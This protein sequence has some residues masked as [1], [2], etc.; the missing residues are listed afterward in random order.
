MENTA[1]ICLKCDSNRLYKDGV[2]YTNEGQI[3]RYLCRV[4]GYRFSESS[5]E[6]HV[7]G[8]VSESLHSGQDDH[9]VRVASRDAS[10]E[11][12]DDDLSFFYGEDVSSHD[13]SIAEK[14]LYDLPFHNSKR[15]L[16]VLEKA[17]K[18]DTATK[19]KNVAGEENQKLTVKGQLLQFALHCRNEGL[20]EETVRIWYNHLK[21]LNKK[22]NL[23]EPESVKEYLSNTTYAQGTKYNIAVIYNA[24]LN[25]IGKTWKRPKYSI[26]E[27]LP[28]F[29]PTEQEIDTLISGCGKKTATILRTI[30]ETGMRI[31]EALRLKWAWLDTERN[32]LTRNNPEKHGRPRAFKVSSKLIGMLTAL[33]KKNELIFA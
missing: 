9:E 8:K 5:V 22:A 16:C 6:V 25:L 33:P 23:D 24:Y 26:E 12:V 11:K 4:C 10:D 30:K 3:Q 27:K 15:Q 18:L 29:I 28:E 21:R 20:T 19:T 1:V 13:I 7:V 31:G 2:R 17:K 32:I 14:S